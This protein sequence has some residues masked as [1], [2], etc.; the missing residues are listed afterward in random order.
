MN[1]NGDKTTGYGM[2]FWFDLCIPSYSYRSYGVPFLLSFLH[3]LPFCRYKTEVTHPIFKILITLQTRLSDAFHQL[4]QND[5]F[6]CQAPL[7]NAKFDLFG[8]ENAS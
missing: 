6:H 1:D 4:V 3:D 2:C 8:S 5:N 7:K